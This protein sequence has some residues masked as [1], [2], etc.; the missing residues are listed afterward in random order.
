MRGVCRD[1]QSTFSNNAPRTE[2]K[3][4]QISRVGVV[5]NSAAVGKTALKIGPRMA[6]DIITNTT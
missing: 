5:E 4:E 6:A 3:Y 2:C 1:H